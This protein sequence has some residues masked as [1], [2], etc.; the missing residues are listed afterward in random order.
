MIF[1]VADDQTLEIVE[2][3][4]DV[5]SSC[6]G[7]DVEDG[8][9]QFFN[10]DGDEL[11]PYF[12]KPNQYGGFWIFKWISSGEFIL[13]HSE[14]SNAHIVS[15]LESIVEVEPNKFFRN[16]DDIKKHFKS[17]MEE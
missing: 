11:V 13:K 5:Q 3:L 14:G 7:A 8:V 10:D 2:S 15:V 1:I 17:K 4:S 9:F 12:T 6:E 16:L